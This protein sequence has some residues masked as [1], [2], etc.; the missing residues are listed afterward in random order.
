MAEIYKIEWTETL[1]RVENIT[2]ESFDE[3]LGIAKELY[4][5]GKV[6]L[7]AENYAGGSVTVENTRSGEEISSDL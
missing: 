4:L 3:A 7:G 2:A 1:S 5:S 6:V